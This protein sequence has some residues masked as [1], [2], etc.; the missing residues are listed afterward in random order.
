MRISYDSYK[1]PTP[2]I[3]KTLLPFVCITRSLIPSF[4]AKIEWGFTDRFEE[5]NTMAFANKIGNLIKQ[6]VST[7]P[8][9]YQS[10]R[11]MSSSKL[12]VGGLSYGTDEQG[13]KDAFSHYGEVVEVRVIL[14][15]ETGRS[16]GFGFVTYTSAEEAQAAITAMDG[17]DLHGRMVRVN[18]ANDRGGSGG[19]GGYGGGQGGYGGGGYGGGQGGYGGGGYG[20]GGGRYGGGQGGYGGGQ[21]GY[22]G[23]GG[24]YSGNSAM[25][26]S[27]GNFGAGFGASDNSFGDDLD[28]QPDYANKRG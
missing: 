17:K 6:S 28:D 24:G 2:L 10:I 23:G 18:T 4:Q 15:R 8:S 12:F 22:G 9:L 26:G 5:V 11:C 21:G 14:D 3:S 20:A 27:G 16:R 1:L 7:S 13:L 25:D 19:G